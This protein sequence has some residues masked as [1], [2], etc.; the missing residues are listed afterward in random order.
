MSASQIFTIIMVGPPLLLCAIWLI[1]DSVL[2]ARE[3]RADARRSV[4]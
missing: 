1:H 4:R 2:I 3:I